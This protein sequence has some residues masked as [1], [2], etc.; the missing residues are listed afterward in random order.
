MLNIEDRV[1]A[2]NAPSKPSANLRAEIARMTEWV[3]ERVKRSKSAIVA[4]R[5][6]LTPVLAA[7]LLDRN[8]K[9]RNISKTTTGR[10]VSD[11]VGGRWAFNG[12]PVIV[13][14]DGQLNDGQH[15]CKA[16]IEAGK[17][18]DTLIVFGPE[19]ETRL[20]VDTG[21]VRTVGNFLSMQGVPNANALAAICSSIWQMKALGRLSAAGDERPTKSEVLLVAE[22]YKDIGDSLAFVSRKGV[23]KVTSPAMMAF[24]HWAI[25]TYGN[26]DAAD[27][28]INRLIDGTNL[29]RGDAVLY[30]RNRLMDLRGSARPQD[31]AELVFR[32]YN[33]E[34][35]GQSCARIVL[36][37]K[38]PKLEK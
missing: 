36:T 26:A 29:R 1:V 16:V 32:S 15:R 22:H 38:L 21:G 24:C 9:N 27:T 31:R 37:G 2:G 18:I 35:L 8:D 19:R 10:L 12:E 3:N 28:F 4:E 13:A 14:K 7:I 5:V 33:A 23:H 30:C 6:T 11:I 25:R 20:T 17:S 34:R